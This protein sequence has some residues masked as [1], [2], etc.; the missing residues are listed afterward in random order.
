MPSSRRIFT[1]GGGSGSRNLN[2]SMDMDTSGDDVAST[3]PPKS[4]LEPLRALADNWDV[5]IAR[6]LEAY[7]DRLA[8][9]TF[10]FSGDKSARLNFAEAALVIENL[11]AFDFEKIY[12]ITSRAG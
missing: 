6:D 1:S 2:S 11:A 12:E 4:L 3:A 8:R 9:V 10:T 5:D 7:A